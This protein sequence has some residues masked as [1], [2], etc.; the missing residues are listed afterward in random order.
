MQTAI[1]KIK[2]KE[3]NFRPFA[4]APGDHSAD[5]RREILNKV[6]LR[7]IVGAGIY[8]LPFPK[9]SFDGSLERGHARGSALPSE[10]VSIGLVIAALNGVTQAALKRPLPS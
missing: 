6:E 1:T 2:S 8:S 4:N 9:C 3:V 7:P 10:A 5:W